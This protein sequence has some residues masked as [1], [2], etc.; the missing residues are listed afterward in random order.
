MS[1]IFDLTYRRSTVIITGLIACLVG[2]WFAKYPIHLRE[3]WLGGLLVSLAAAPLVRHK[4]I[5][6]IIIISL[7]GLSIGLARGVSVEQNIRR[8]SQLFGQEVSIR[9]RVLDDSSY[10][11]NGQ[12]QFF[13]SDIRIENCRRDCKLVGKVRVRSRL[14]AAPVRG[15]Q[16]KVNGVMREGF[17]SYQAAIYYA[18]VIPISHWISWFE[19]MRLQF[20]TAMRN[21]IPEPQASLG[22]GFLIGLQA[23]LPETLLSELRRT[24]LT[25]IVAVSGYNLTVLVRLTRRTFAKQSKFFATIFAFVLI[26]FFMMV[27]GLAPSIFRA[28]V[29]AVVS[30][31]SWYYGR[32]ARPMMLLGLSGVFT[33]MLSPILLWSD[34]GWWLSFLA[35]FGVLVVG[36]TFSLRFFHKPPSELPFFGQ[37]I[38]ETSSAQL[39]TLPLTVHTFGQ[40]SVV[41]LLANMIVLPVIPIA[42]GFS[43]IAVIGGMISTVFGPI[44]AWPAYFLLLSITEIVKLLS[45]IPFAFIDDITFSSS[46]MIVSYIIVILILLFWQRRLSKQEKMSLQTQNYLD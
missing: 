17:S 8:Y 44:V 38:L 45:A 20:F 42:M 46:A 28:S 21:V 5:V 9:G 4:K 2:I 24:G 18:E 15:Q 22:L 30:L 25:H 6:A 19:H 40:L 43:F 32:S 1:S 3:W 11:K 23:L 31:W 27:T 33:A 7:L 26:A 34:L 36:P 14:N 12:R 39:M 37:I 29:V 13:I 41:S 35:F 16:V 10:G